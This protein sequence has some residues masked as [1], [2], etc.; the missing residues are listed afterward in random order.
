MKT[1]QNPLTRFFNF[2]IDSLV[3][4]L[5]VVV[6]SFL[7]YDVVPIEDMRIYGIALYYAYY[8]LME[9]TL[10][11]TVGKM[12]TKTKVIDA[13]SENP[14]TTGQVFL[15][16]L[17]RLIPV[18]WVSYFVSIRGIHDYTSRTNLINIKTIKN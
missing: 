18:D 6:M 4:F 9:L 14:P 11:Q 2:L 5:L 8:F 17:S 7:L 3:I 15:R 16:T 10:G 12:V 13:R 1:P